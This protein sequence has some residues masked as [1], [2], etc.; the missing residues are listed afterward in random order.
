[1][2]VN[3]VELQLGKQTNL[4]QEN[5]ADQTSCF[6]L[7]D[8]VK[9]ILLSVADFV[10]LEEDRWTLAAA[11]AADHRQL[12]ELMKELRRRLAQHALDN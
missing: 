5:G 4:L 6:V 10:L 11:T 7:S 9:D 1:V 8:G 3:R 12:L 2:T